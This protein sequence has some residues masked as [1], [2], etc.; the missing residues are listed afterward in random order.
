MHRIIEAS[1][2]MA[3]D[4]SRWPA[5]DPICVNAGPMLGPQ[6][7]VVDSA[8][9]NVTLWQKYLLRMSMKRLT[10]LAI[11]MGTLWAG[12]SHAADAGLCKSMC[13]AE[14]RECRANVLGQAR[15]DGGSL[16]EMGERN[17]MAR[18][19]Q[20]QV[21][22]QAAR[23][24]DNAG[25]QTRRIDK[26]GKCDATYLRCTRACDAPADASLVKQPPGR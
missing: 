15:D 26:A 13:G 7:R 1:F 11:V 20:E 21:P 6:Q 12:A 24:I 2:R 3:I 23:A 19:A 4:I 14:K 17:P 9:K 22:A 25:T 18:A 10:L 8:W 5:P 16:L